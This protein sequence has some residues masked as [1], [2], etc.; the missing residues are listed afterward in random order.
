M[1]CYQQAFGGNYEIGIRM[2]DYF[3]DISYR[4]DTGPAFT[5]TRG[6]RILKICVLPESLQ[7][8]EI[9]GAY[10]YTLMEMEAD[11]E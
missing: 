10:R 5:Y 11:G 4:H 7:D 1:A 9:T 3:Q 6:H 2:P 8:R